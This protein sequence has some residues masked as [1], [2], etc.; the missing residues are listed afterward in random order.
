MPHSER[1]AVVGGPV[2]FIM[3]MC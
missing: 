1:G 2:E 3:W